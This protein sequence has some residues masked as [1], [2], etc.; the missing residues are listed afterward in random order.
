MNFKTMTLA[1]AVV[2]AGHAM[3]EAKTELTPEQKA[4]RRESL[5]SRAGGLVPRKGT[6]SGRIV[7]VN[8]QKRIPIDVFKGTFAKNAT[9]VKGV[10]V[11]TGVESASVA[12]ANAIRRA[13]GAQFAIIIV[14]SPGMPMSLIALEEGWA[15]MNVNALDDGKPNAELL[16][17][18]S[19][20]EFARIFGILCGGASSQFK[21][22]I[23]NAVSKPSDLNGCTDEL[24]VDI[25]A[26]MPTYL[27][28]HGVKSL[29]LVPYRHA[30]QEGWAMPP[31]N[32]VQ[33][34]IWDQIHRIPDKPMTIEFDPKANK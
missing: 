20:N 12:N 30:V 10:D 32:D 16:Q 13:N 4:E 29:Q 33:K 24:P 11:W 14:D 15:M 8:A 34:A 25:L 3:S 26:K 7:F 17:H 28:T 5:I 18:R 1:L 22:H 19:Q 27:E 9:K 31:T 21:S 6:P 23:M 2:S